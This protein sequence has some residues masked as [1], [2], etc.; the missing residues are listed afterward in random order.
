MF[1]LPFRS[2][3]SS[4]TLRSIIPKRIFQ[5][6]TDATSTSRLK[7]KTILVTGASRGIGLAIAERYAYSGASKVVLIGRNE[8]TLK[9]V[10]DAINNELDV[11]VKGHEYRV[12]D[13]ADRKF[14]VELGKE[15]VRLSDLSYGTQLPVVSVTVAKDGHRKTSTSL[16]TLR[17]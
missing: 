17:G 12:G 11:V 15:W 6:S 8:A 14:W 9:P 10:T 5:Y 2:P 3:T 7:S 4:K 1:H 16:S 13:V